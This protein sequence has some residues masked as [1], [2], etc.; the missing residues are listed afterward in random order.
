V[1]RI[2][3]VLALIGSS[4]ARA[5]D[6][7]G[8]G[9]GVGAGI[10]GFVG[11]TMRE[12]SAPGASWD[13]RLV[14][15]PRMPASLEVAYTGTAA[16]ITSPMDGVRGTLVGTGVEACA[17]ATWTESGRWRPYAFLGAGWRRYSVVRG[18]FDLA[19]SGMKDGDDLVVFPMG[20]G[21][22]YRAGAL[23]FDARLTVRATGSSHFALDD[24]GAASPTFTSMDTWGLTGRLEVEL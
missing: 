13:L 1:A 9:L 7:L 15:D 16:A 23:T 14:A 11:R 24:P 3:C 5:D 2:A 6:R 20:F 19:S 18:A 12:A 22:G 10:E 8:V 4:A 17:R 21:L